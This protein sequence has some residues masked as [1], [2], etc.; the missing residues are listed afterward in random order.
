MEVCVCHCH[1]VRVALKISVSLWLCLEQHTTTNA[2][3]IMCAVCMDFTP[4][5][6]RKGVHFTLAMF[7]IAYQIT[8][9]TIS[10]VYAGWKTVSH[11]LDFL[12]MNHN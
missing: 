1:L 9:L 7:R 10:A 11:N 8:T 5:S 3:C 2:V 4:F 12:Q 6:N